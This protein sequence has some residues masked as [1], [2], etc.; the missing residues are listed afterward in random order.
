M[1]LL[2]LAL[3][4]PASG[5]VLQIPLEREA[6]RFAQAWE[7][8]D[9]RLLGEVMASGGIRLHMPGEQ[10]V[11]I[12]P[13]QAQA[14]LEAF[15]GRYEGGETAVTRV[16]MAGGDSGKGFA[17]IQWRTGSPGVPEPVIFTVF[18]A[19]ALESGRWVV[20]EIRVLF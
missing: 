1:I 8:E 20:T 11:L 3:S 10:H 7:G 19:Y 2:F 18:V 9:T 6:A 5:P 16:S 12:R 4:L 17:E 14:A 15:L 13:R